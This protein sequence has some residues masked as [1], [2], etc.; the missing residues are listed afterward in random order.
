MGVI[1]RYFAA[2]T[3]ELAA[4]TIDG[5]GGPGAAVASVEGFPAVEE[6]GFDPVVQAGTL[7]AILTSRTYEDIEASPG[8]ARV[9]AERD[10]GE[11]LVVALRDP[12][13]SALA[14]ST[15][16]SRREVSAR[17]AETEEFWG[18]ADPGVLARRLDELSVL[19]RAAQDSGERLYCLVCV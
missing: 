13:V 5:S 14:D 1:Y 19:A 2:P 3:D 4:G 12:L 8:R 7:E 10:G 17:W 6:A 11:R 16:E 9:V 18:Q 15:P